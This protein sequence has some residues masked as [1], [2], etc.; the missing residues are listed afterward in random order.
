MS[1]LTITHVAISS[2]NCGL[3]WKPNLVKNSTET[4]PTT[5]THVTR[6]LPSKTFP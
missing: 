4:C 2:V 3:N 1:S 5:G 6:R